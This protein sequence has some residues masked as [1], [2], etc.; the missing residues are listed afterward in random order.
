MVLCAVLTL[1][2][3]ACAGGPKPTRL[4]AEVVTGP[5]VN[6]RPD[7]TPAPVVV[8]IYGLRTPEA[9][10]SADFFAL[11]ENDQTL[12]GAALLYR[13]ERLMNPG[14]HWR[15]Q[16]ELP[17]DARYLGAIAAFR[18][19]DRA[20]WRALSPLRPG[21]RN[22]VEVVLENRRIEIHPRH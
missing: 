12:L 3:F 14:E 4:S 22:R 19:I 21:K 10:R 8:R 11:Y 17:A 1:G 2:L 18:D 16:A 6:V 7:G 13:E 5:S 9:F 20:R 15:I